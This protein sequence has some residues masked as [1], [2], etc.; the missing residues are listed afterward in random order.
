MNTPRTTAFVTGASGFIGS[1]LVDALQARG[2]HVRALLRKTSSRTNLEAA[3]ANG[4]ELVEGTLSDTDAMRD[5]LAGV[6]LVFH[7]AGLTAAFSRDELVR[8]NTEGTANLLEAARTATPT[9]RRVILVSTLEAAGPT[10]PSL[11]RREYHKVDPY[12]DYGQSKA[13]GERVAYEVARASALDI[14]VVR[15]PIVYGPRDVDMLENVRAARMG[16]AAAPGLGDKPFSIVHV[17][18]LVRGILD[19]ADRGQPLPRDTDDHVLA[20]G[21]LP[22][23]E[24]AEDPCHPAGRGI[25][26]FCDGGRWR[27]TDFGVAAGKA[28]DRRVVALRIPGPLVRVIG[29]MTH[30]V[31]RVRG[32]V[33]ALTLDKIRG[34]LGSGWW[35]ASDKAIAELGWAPQVSLE[36]GMTR[37]I[38]WYREQGWL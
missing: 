17:D 26:Y 22:K 2:L 28:M 19:V 5:A 18:D 31:G 35:C 34:A 38:A 1:A 6:D 10:D 27:F 12:T 30:A 36:D 32:K 15:P 33:P 11:A 8:A 20:M 14:L 9:P 4:L 29:G 23:T 7:V 16:V 37:T 13:G 3:L 25:Y 24:L 21:G